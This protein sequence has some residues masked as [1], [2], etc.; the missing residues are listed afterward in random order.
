MVVDGTNNPR[1]CSSASR[2]RPTQA[3]SRLRRDQGPSWPRASASSIR[4][5]IVRSVHHHPLE[6]LGNPWK[7]FIFLDAPVMVPFLAIKWPQVPKRSQPGSRVPRLVHFSVGGIF[8][9]SCDGGT[10]MCP[11]LPGTDPYTPPLRN[12]GIDCHED[13]AISGRRGGTDRQRTERRRR[14]PLPRRKDLSPWGRRCAPPHSNDSG[15]F[16]PSTTI[17]WKSLG[18][19]GNSS[20]SLMLP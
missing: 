2:T 16:V 17:P 7:S 13:L 12:P 18:I 15:L 20:Y 14:P 6:I 9:R 8:R 5:R 19:L 1:A 11:R 3:P 4:S 10:R